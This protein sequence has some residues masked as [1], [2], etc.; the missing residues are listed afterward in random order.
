MDLLKVYD[1][2]SMTRNNIDEVTYE[3][4]MKKHEI[5]FLYKKNR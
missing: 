2:S 1:D 4:S 3:R 5:M